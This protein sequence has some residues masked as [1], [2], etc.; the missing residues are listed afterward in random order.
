MD[1]SLLKEDKRVDA[2]LSFGIIVL[3]FLLRV[4]GIGFGLPDLYHADEPVIVNHA[5]AYAS[6]DFNPHFFRIPP[7]VSYLMFGVYG[8]IYLAGKAAGVFSNPVDFEHL[9]YRDPTL[10]YVSGR[11]LFGAL[12]GTATIAVWRRA[13]EE[14]A[15]KSVANLTAL[16]LA[17][18]VLF[19]RDSHYLYA[20]I[21]LMLLSA[22]FFQRLLRMAKTGA[23]GTADLLVCGFFW[24]AAIAVKYNACFLIVPYLYFLFRFK[25]VLRAWIPLCV[26]GLTA[27][28]I[29]GALN[30]YGIADISFFLKEMAAERG[31]HAGTAWEHH[32][33]Y[34]LA[35]GCGWP[36]IMLSALGMGAVFL[37]RD[38]GRMCLLIFVGVYYF[39]IVRWGQE[40]ARYALPIVP[41]L[42]FFAADAVFRISRLAP[43][44]LRRIALALVLSAT[45]AL[46][47]LWASLCLTKITLVPDTRSQTRDWILRNLPPG[48]S[49][50]LD[51][52]FFMP[53]LGFT[54]EQ[55]E[56]KRSEVMKLYSF[57]DARLRKV[58]WLLKDKASQSSGYRLFFLGDPASETG[59]P[60]YARPI[61]PFSSE[62]L[63]K[64]GVLIVIEAGI[65]HDP[66]AENFFREIA[67]NS[68]VLARFS[69]YRDGSDRV[70]DF[71]AVT[72]LPLTIS[73]LTA[74]RSAGP[75]IVIYRLK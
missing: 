8:L 7:L 71:N 60:L 75:P 45:V 9:F 64:R 47:S 33:V 70:K 11:F 31:A 6:G 46:P 32:W 43:E 69:P 26:T 66:E 63:R 48:T 27:C 22:F 53:R 29:Y 35:E 57:R 44:G 62:E 12:A 24:G 72:G 50:A 41:P 21:P 54:G 5:L 25:G 4:T 49:L 37:S 73:D 67:E 19:V 2:F 58:E 34:S 13:V 16:F 18:N 15:G 68:E 36:L 40:P 10:F 55:L 20:D 61:L 39:V 56:V 14:Y 23:S 30:P 1:P 74:R 28:L 65:R 38:T 51:T 59:R 17:V 52:D 42:C 3:A